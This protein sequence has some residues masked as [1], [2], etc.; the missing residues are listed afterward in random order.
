[1]MEAKNIMQAV[2]EA[3]TGR[4][5]DAAG[6]VG[7]SP[8]DFIEMAM[9]WMIGMT[10]S[11]PDFIRAECM[12]FLDGQRSSG[13]ED[14][15]HRAFLRLHSDNFTAI[16]GSTF[17]ERSSEHVTHEQVC[18]SEILEEI[19]FKRSITEASA[20]ALGYGTSILNEPSLR[21][22]AMALIAF[23]DAIDTLVGAQNNIAA[24]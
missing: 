16:H 20:I 4:I 15:P 17:G 22:E 5:A 10:A 3:G 14:K 9:R 23:S 11:S 24:V 18:F 21:N 19:V 1:M 7:M 8:E 13:D 2:T 12:P 6:K